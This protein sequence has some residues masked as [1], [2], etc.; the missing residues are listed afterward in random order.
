MPRIRVECPKCHSEGAWY[1]N[2]HQDV[3]LRCL[4][5]YCKVV[6]TKLGNLTTM[7]IDAGDNVTLPRRESKL[8]ACLAILIGLQR[9]TSGQITETTNVGR[10]G[11]DVQSNSDI[12]SQLTV[13]RYK[14]LVKVVVDAKGL[15]G[16]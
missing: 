5:G 12:A 14:G 11:S 8:F 3:W 4:C 7:H 15:P 9:A 2:D 13:L 6:E 10:R 1:E 16:G